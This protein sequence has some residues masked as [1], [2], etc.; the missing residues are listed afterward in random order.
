[1]ETSIK[2]IVSDTARLYPPLWGGPKRIWNL[3][4]R[5]SRDKFNIDYV[6]IDF[7]L[8]KNYQVVK[9]SSNFR[10]FLVSRPFLHRL[11]YPLH[12]VFF[13]DLSFDL[14]TYLMMPAV[15]EFKRIFRNLKADILIS[16]HPWAAS[17][18]KK[19]KKQLFIYDAH[20]CEYILMKSLTKDKFLGSLICL[21]TKNI[22][23]AACKKSDTILVCSE[24]EK[25]DFVRIYKVPA[26][27]IYIIPNGTKIKPLP[28]AEEKIEKKKKLGLFGKKIIFFVGAYYKPNIEAFTYIVNYLAPQLNDYIFLIVGTVRD[29]FKNVQLPKNI[30]TFG[31]VFDDELDEITAA[32]DIAINPIFFGSGINIKVLDY[33]SAGLPTISTK[34]GARGIPF[35]NFKNMIV[36]DEN[37]FAINIKRLFNHTEVHERLKQNGRKLAIEH[38]DWAKISQNLENILER[39]TFL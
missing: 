22:E 5:L 38:F 8:K 39:E 21:W 16:S 4:S 15:K 31:R 29:A 34:I 23:R 18:M 32:S 9:L 24:K 25:E 28:T 12:K 1:M 35:E 33:L 27:K 37:E 19:N 13:K 6:G 11:W 3:Y 20:N 7:S 36:C 14:F 17:C 30:R 2:V 26:D 10:E